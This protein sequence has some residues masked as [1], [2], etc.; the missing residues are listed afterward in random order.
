MDPTSLPTD[1]LY[2]FMALSGVALVGLILWLLAKAQRAHLTNLSVLETENAKHKS[3]VDNLSDLERLQSDRE[4][5]IGD[6]FE[7]LKQL[8][9][10]GN[11]TA[12]ALAE[13]AKVREEMEAAKQRGDELL[14]LQHRLRAA[15]AV[16]DAVASGVKRELDLNA[17][18]NR[19]YSLVFLFAALWSFAGF[20]LWYLNLQRPT[21]AKM[22]L[23][24]EVTT[25]DLQ[26]KKASLDSVATAHRR[27]AAAA[28][29]SKAP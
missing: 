8:A 22:R 29:P 3:E 12:T 26:L 9:A 18:D 17:R 16:L 13:L 19:R 15:R 14:E 10:S 2:K 25:A 4:R 27:A 23:E 21:D 20:G 24:A 11:V 7:A 5:A 28:I 6:R 1:S